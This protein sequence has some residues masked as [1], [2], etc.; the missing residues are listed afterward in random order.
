ML[1]KGNRQGLRVRFARDAHLPTRQRVCAIRLDVS[2][3]HEALTRVEK[4]FKTISQSPLI[5]LARA[6][7]LEPQVGGPFA[8]WEWPAVAEPAVD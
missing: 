5:R 2:S 1:S 4:L 7:Q 6:L 8:R 3:L